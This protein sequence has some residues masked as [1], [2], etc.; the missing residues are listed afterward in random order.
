MTD[1]LFRSDAYLR[2]T[3]A[4]VLAVDDGGITLDRTVFYAQS[5]GQPGDAGT[6]RAADGTVLEIVDTVYAADRATVLHRFA[7]GTNPMLRTGDRVTAELDWPQRFGRMRIHTAL[8]LLT[9]VL[10]YPVTG[11]AIGDREG[12]LDFDMPAGGQDRDA[13]ESGLNDLIGRDAPVTFHWI[14]DDELLASP[15]LVKTMSVKPPMGSGR[16]RLVQIGDI[17]LQPCGGTHVARTSEIG[18][19]SVTGIEKKGKQNRRIR[20]AFGEDASQTS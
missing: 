20:I 1:L 3:P 13:I 16:V 7:P 10:P 8:H 15:G 9:A 6:L 17:D 19:V 14:T 2:S 12:R 11:G 18:R 4:T 5:G